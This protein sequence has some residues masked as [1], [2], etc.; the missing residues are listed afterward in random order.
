[1]V[2]AG[3]S[4]SISMDHEFS[5][6]KSALL[7]GDQVT[8]CSPSAWVIQGLGPLASMNIDEMFELVTHILSSS[9][10]AAAGPTAE[11]SSMVSGY[12]KILLK[13]KRLTTRENIAKQ[14]ILRGYK[15]VIKNFQE[16]NLSSG[17]T[18]LHKLI[19]AGHI[20]LHQFAANDMD[21]VIEE[22]VTITAGVIAD[23][24][25]YPLFDD[26]SGGLVKELEK[27][28]G[29]TSEVDLK[30]I[31]HIHLADNLFHLLPDLSTATLDEVIDI[32]EELKK[33]LLNFRSK[34]IEMSN[35]VSSAVWDKDFP[36]EVQLLKTSIIDPAIL[37]I[38]EQIR[39]SKS[40]MAFLAKPKDLIN[41]A[42]IP[43]SVGGFISQYSHLD[44]L[45]MAALGAVIG[46]SA[47][48]LQ[49][50]V[51][52]KKAAKKNQLYFYYHLI[53]KLQ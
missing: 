18:Q 9:P 23:G 14:Q 4:G 19:E 20:K 22:F 29:N 40:L 48:A 10:Q 27:E 46:T 47:G 5:L 52:S 30:R 45:T 24:T 16:F 51:E 36:K 26:D 17:N 34:M 28:K 37:E 11:M 50:I 13:K 21:S 2:L 3:P 38:S 41:A 1:M 7:Y 8:L 49:K 33:Y 43:S 15:Q 42:T 44:T 25:A 53:K 32:R 31:K 6:L 12:S 35:S 39:T